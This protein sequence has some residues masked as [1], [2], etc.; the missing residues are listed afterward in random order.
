MSTYVTLHRCS[1]NFRTLK[2]SNVRN[3]F[4]HWR[5]SFCFEH[6]F[7]I[8][9]CKMSLFR[10]FTSTQHH[11]GKAPCKS[12]HTA[13]EN[14]VEK[15]I[16]TPGISRKELTCVT[17]EL[18]HTDNEST[19]ARRVTY[20]E[21]TKKKVARYALQH[22]VAAAVRKY[23]KE[24]PKLRQSTVSPWLKRY[25]Q[26]ETSSTSQ[27]TISTKRGRPT[28]LSTEL[29]TKLRSMIINL[30]IAGA[31]INIHDIKGVLAGLVRSNVAAY[32]AYIGFH[33][34][35]S[36]VRSLYTVRPK[37]QIWE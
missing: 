15:N 23:E 5:V 4:Y 31:Q 33:V 36:W 11:E 8:L 37:S 9:S 32:G 29:D 18:G 20:S 26:V 12:A 6:T 28:Y 22:G 7:L 24:F 3:S 21:N 16:S 30:R 17:E 1:N 19:P 2:Y 13:A 14:I 25:K 10:Y 27:A 35:R 34:T